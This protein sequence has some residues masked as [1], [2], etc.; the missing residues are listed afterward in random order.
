MRREREGGGEVGGGL[1]DIQE[2]REKAVC[3]ELAINT[4]YLGSIIIKFYQC[5]TF[6]RLPVKKL[7][8]TVTYISIYT[9]LKSHDHTYPVT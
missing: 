4:T 7:S 2:G 6:F 5:S 3:Q 9:H 8:A 1:V